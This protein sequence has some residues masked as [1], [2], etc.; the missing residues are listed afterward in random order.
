M[1][2]EEAIKRIEWLRKEINRHNYLYYVLNKPEISDEEYDKLMQELISL[3]QKY[4][5]LIT[6]DSPT[7]RVGAPPAE[8]FKTVAHVKPMLSLDTVNDVEEVISF[9]KRVKKEVGSE[10]I[11]YV[12]EPKMDGLSVE[13]IYENGRY[14]RGSTRGDG[15]NGE[16]ITE[17]IRT[18]K[19]VPLL[20]RGEEI[21]PPSFLAVRGEVIMHI[22]DFEKFNKELIE[23]GEEPMANPR[24]AAS[25]SLRRLDPRETAMR[26]L[27]IFFYEI[28][29]ADGIEIKTQWEALELLKKWGLKTNPHSIKC[30]IIEEA[31]KYHEEMNR[32]REELS[33]E[34][35]GVVIKVNEIKYQT[36][37][38][39]KTRSPRWAIAYKFPPRK[40]ETQ[41]MN[42]VV[43]VGRTGILTPVALLKPV[44]V[45]GVT[46]SRA[47]LHNEDYVKQKDVRIGDWVRV[48]RAG[49]VIP[50]VMEV[51]KERRTGNEKIFSMPD[52]CPVCGSSVVR[53]GAYYRCTGGLSCISQLK[54]SIEHF[55]SKRAMDIEGLGGKT[56]ELLVDRGIIKRVSDIYKIKKEDL[57]NLPR[58][59]DKSA[60]NLIEG[61]EKSKEKDLARFI[62]AL[63]IPNVGEHMAKLLAEKFKD[64]DTLMNAKE[65]DLMSVREIGPETASSIV[66]FFKEE[67]NRNEIE[68]LKKCGI[69]M[70]YEET[71]GKLSGIT[72]VFTGELKSFSREEAKEIVE[73]M[74]GGVASSVS[75][76][77]D[78]VVVGENPGSK[79]E[80]A[81][82]LGLKIINEE[83]FKKIIGEGS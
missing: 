66:N 27:D 73:K 39:E 20:L 62:Y 2:K 7:Q 40:E 44:D 9:D 22:E 8:E 5:D 36:L 72:F 50:E 58:F 67:K 23:K 71:R 47:T 76:K 43:Q 53:D 30:S 59:G 82:E 28:M 52:K 15:I 29:R 3:E 25:G 34:I 11:E 24:N 70:K 68:E 26:P 18:I 38:G 80:K 13:L 41:V 55:A 69:K 19:A 81:K 77:V 42:I 10:N 79:Y 32:K 65:E 37:L 75:K 31:I 63:G 74:G 48:G 16:D 78:Y 83:E 14:I 64:I 12:A 49:D 35:D 46:V 45:K 1:D 6:P 54:R 17:N 51:I 60:E 57:L 33:Y 4:P 21:K 56:V 61:I